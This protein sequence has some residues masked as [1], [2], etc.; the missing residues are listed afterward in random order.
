MSF[1]Y[2]PLAEAATQ[3]ITMSIGQWNQ[4]KQQT[5]QLEANLNLAAEKLKEQKNTSK[6]LLTQLQEA[7][8]Q[9]RLTQ[10]ALTN[11]NR[12]LANVRESLKR[13]EDLYKTLTRKMESENRKNRR[14]KYQRNIYAG[15]AAFA[16]AYAAAK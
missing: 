14:V 10:E 1:A 11:S 8:K 9:L 16:I 13:S 6:E 4:F 5:N 12:S 2:T 15:C 3:Q 7:Q